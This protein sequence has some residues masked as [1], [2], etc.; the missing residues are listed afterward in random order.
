MGIEITRIFHNVYG[1]HNP[2]RTKHRHQISHHVL[3]SESH[4]LQS[5]IYSLK[6]KRFVTF[7]CFLLYNLQQ[8]T[9]HV[10]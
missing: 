3:L 5:V 4:P 2:I 8:C 10:K 9:T 6:S 1:Y 7:S